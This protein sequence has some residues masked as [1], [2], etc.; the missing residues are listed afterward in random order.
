MKNKNDCGLYVVLLL[1]LIFSFLFC[2]VLYGENTFAHTAS[3]T[4]SG[5]VNMNVSASGDGANLGTSNITIDSTCPLGYTVS[6]SGPVDNTLYKNGNSTNNMAGQTINASTGTTVSPKPILGDDGNGNSYVGTWGYT[7]DSDATINSNFIGLTNT[8]TTLITKNSASAVG[9]DVIAV[10][11]GVSVSPELEPGLYTLAESSAGA[12]D[13]VITYYLTT[14]VNCNSYTIKYDDNGAN[15]TT[16]MTGMAHTVTENAEVTLAPSNYQRSNY[17]FAGWSTEQL[18]PDSVNFQTNLVAAKAAGHVFGPM[19][20]ITVD[21]ALLSQATVSNNTQV[22]TMYALWVPSAGNIQ[23]W[24]GCGSMSNGSVTALTD[25]RDSQTYAVAKLAD[26]KC[27]MIENLRLDNTNSDNSTGNLTQGYSGGGV[28]AGL[29]DPESPW[30]SNITDENSLYTTDTTS[31]TKN[32]ITGNNL[33]YRIPR[34]NHQNTDS[35]TVISTNYPSNMDANIYSYGNYYTWAAAMANTNDYTGPTTQANGKT[36]ETVGTSICPKGWQLPYGRNTG[37]GITAGGFYNLNYKI[38]NDANVTDAAASNLLRQYPN[39]FLYSGYVSSSSVSNRG[40]RGS[41][42]SSTASNNNSSYYLRLN[43]SD[44]GPGA[45][46][47]NKNYGFTV[48]CVVSDTYTISYDANGGTGTMGD[49]TAFSNNSAVIATNAFTYS[50]HNFIGWNTAA[51]GSGASYADGASV[52]NLTT[53]NGVATLYAQWEEV[54]TKTISEITYF[55][56][57]ASLSNS[58]KTS[59]LNSMNTGTAYSLIDSRD[60]ITYKVSKLADGRVWMIENL[61]LDIADTAVQANLD[62]STTN[63][64][65]TALY[66]LINGGGSSPYCSTA[67]SN[68]TNSQQWML[69]SAKIVTDYKNSTTTHF[70]AGAGKRGIYYNNWAAS[71]GSYCTNS[72]SLMELP[73]DVCPAGWRLPT[74]NGGEYQ[75]L[76][77]AYNDYTNLRN[78]FSVTLSGEFET[79]S[80]NGVGSAGWYWTSSIDSDQKAYIASFNS[81][82]YADSWDGPHMGFPIRCIAK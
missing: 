24:S 75:N 28:F 39:N 8:I 43:S 61:A 32:I 35:D 9:G 51:D 34:Y 11:Y 46:N 5:M 67:V 72:T 60:N 81:S 73:G 3:I 50:G 14:S 13:D 77:S 55:Q 4:T 78:A 47:L 31:T 15:S 62:S 18:D 29:A 1:G 25:Q 12:G 59:V 54:S 36:S 42:W 53:I 30:P 40:S 49:Q 38:N 19:E 66:H 45:Y 2:T 71:G 64:S 20:T 33:G 27:W 21:S 57:F 6:I 37:N 41:Y 65:D 69:L 17:G 79:G 63:A 22:I 56:E 58:A 10:R 7:V 48:R 80:F 74:G 76:S 26:D 70:G 23:S 44:V 16:T 52:M 68:N 82:S